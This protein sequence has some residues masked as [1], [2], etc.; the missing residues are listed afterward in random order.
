MTRIK[1]TEQYRN[2]IRLALT[3][4]DP[5]MVQDALY[6]VDE[7]LRSE[8]SSS[9]S[10][11]TEQ[12]LV[13]RAIAG[14]GSPQEVAASYRATEITVSKALETPAPVVSFLSG[15]LGMLIDPKAYGAL[16]LMLFGLL[17]GLFYFTWAVVGLSMSLG[18]GILIFGVPFFIGFAM[19]LRML[20]LVEGRLLEALIGVRMP[21]RPVSLPTEKGWLPKARYWLTDSLTW[22]TLLYCLLSLPLG[23][24][25]FVVSVTLLSLALSF[26]IGPFAQLIFDRPLV[27]L[28][29]LEWFVPWW[30]FP[31]LWLTTVAIGLLLMYL[32]VVF[33][34]LRAALAKALLVA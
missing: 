22:K 34:K 25:T 5:A 31:G 13:D 4:S 9:A 7:F 29:S 21:R 33:G 17:T 24:L 11:L 28:G 1:T 12:E 6:D 20:G 16:F 26:F 18:F 32:A 14:F 2:A 27:V 15:T 30:L 3:A 19:S 8:R 10:D 23:I